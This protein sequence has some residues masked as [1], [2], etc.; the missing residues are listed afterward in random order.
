M[1]LAKIH[2]RPRDP[3]ANPTSS[4]FNTL[5]VKEHTEGTV[6]VTVTDG[7]R[8][9]AVFV[10][11]TNPESIRAFAHGL[12]STELWEETIAWMEDEFPEKSQFWRVTCNSTGFEGS[13]IA[14]NNIS[15]LH[16]AVGDALFMVC[17]SM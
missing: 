6:K 15:E 7:D 10:I 9:S 8:N 13:Y 12:T 5:V 14:A 11:P 1:A 2:I 3:Q 4:V 17:S 16:T